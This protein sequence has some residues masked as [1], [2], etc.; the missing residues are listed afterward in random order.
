MSAADSSESES[1]SI[2]FTGDGEPWCTASQVSNDIPAA[3]VIEECQSQKTYR[4]LMKNLRTSDIIAK[5]LERL[6]LKAKPEQPPALPPPEDAT[7]S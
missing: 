1:S 6:D 2:S 3:E 5:A 7:P 4:L